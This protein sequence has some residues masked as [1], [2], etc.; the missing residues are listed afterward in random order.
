MPKYDCP[1]PGRVL[2]IVAAALLIA[3]C[4][5][6]VLPA[7][8][9]TAVSSAGVAAANPLAVDAGLEVLGRGGSAADAAVAVQAM[10]G[11]VEPQSSGAGGGG[12]LL[13]YDA[14]SGRVTAFDG[15]EAAP[16]GAT[17]DMFIG[18]DSKPL[19][20]AEAV[21]SGR[22]TGVPGVMPMLGAA[23]RLH[24]RLPW[25]TLFDAAIRTAESG[26]AVPQ[27]LARFVNGNWPQSSSPDVRAL[28]S[29]P[30][31]SPVQAGDTYTNPAY[32]AT[33]RR[34]AGG[35]SRTLLESPVAERIVARTSAAPLPVLA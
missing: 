1:T 7:A 13:H 16:A 17:A 28:F 18:E 6:A 11:L 30:D 22:S 24:G 19:G 27:R 2:A 12:F 25:D 23:H 26:F 34:L 35:R 4:Q 5:R 31:G 33:L 10:L 29:R 21:T 3:A 9:P 20:Y 15:R 32:A 14:R 8:G